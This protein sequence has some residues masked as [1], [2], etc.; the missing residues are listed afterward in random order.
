M[1]SPGSSAGPRTARPLRPRG[2]PRP[3]APQEP[4]CRCRTAAA[5]SGVWRAAQMREPRWRPSGRRRSTALEVS[6]HTAPTARQRLPQPSSRPRASPNATACVH[7][8]VGAGTGDASAP[9]HAPRG[10]DMGLVAW[11]CRGRLAMPRP[12]AKAT[13]AG[14]AHRPMPSRLPK[15]L[16]QPACKRSSIAPRQRVAY[17]AYAAL[18]LCLLLKYSATPLCV[19]TTPTWRCACSTTSAGLR[20]R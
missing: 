11:A 12:D 3:P 4:E 19:S 6:S 7:A 13:Q 16:L 1:A 10:H 8:C 17:A 9:S 18:S 2:R 14:I 20:Q 5:A 15:R